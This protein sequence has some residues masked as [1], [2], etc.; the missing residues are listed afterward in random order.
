MKKLRQEI[1]NSINNPMSRNRL[2]IKLTCDAQAVAVQIRQNNINGRLTRMDAL[3][4]ISEEVGVP[5]D[6][7]LE[8]AMADAQDGDSDKKIDA[9]NAV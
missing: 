2:G 3:E 6:Q 4:A 8:D 7:L 9:A 5:V 1:I